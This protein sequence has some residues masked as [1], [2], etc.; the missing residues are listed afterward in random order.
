VKHE[1]VSMD[2]STRERIP[3]TTK[4][5]LMTGVV[6]MVFLFVAGLAA[7]MALSKSTPTS[8]EVLE[9]SPRHVQVWFT[10]APD[11]AVS[12]L[13]LE[14]AAGTIELGALTILDDKSIKAAVPAMLSDGAYTV[15]WR[16]AGDDGH[17]QRGNFTFTVRARP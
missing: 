17:T 11:P 1:A 16:S 8:G 4:I 7:H 6:A 13:T 9:E 12:R 14:S 3:M 15:N 5:R 2:E 10:Q